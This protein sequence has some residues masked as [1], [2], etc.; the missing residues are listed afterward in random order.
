ME[1][2]DG[3]TDEPLVLVP[4]DYRLRPQP[5]PALA[6]D[7]LPAQSQTTL[8]PPPVLPAIRPEQTLV[9]RYQ[10]ALEAQQVKLRGLMD[11]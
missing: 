6:A 1:L 8:P 3:A 9:E 11:P 10:Q 2:P 4:A 7:Q 5:L